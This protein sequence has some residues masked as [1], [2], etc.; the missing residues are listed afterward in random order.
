MH[1]HGIGSGITLA[2]ADVVALIKR[3]PLTKARFPAVQDLFVGV[4]GME[5]VCAR[6][7]NVLETRRDMAPTTTIHWA[8]EK[9]GSCVHPT[10]L[11][12]PTINLT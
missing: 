3:N 8:T 10:N 1:G 12:L 5:V 9:V 11:S 7:R 6:G 4:D 2:K